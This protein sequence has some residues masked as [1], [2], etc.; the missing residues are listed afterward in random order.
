MI[1]VRQ[2]GLALLAAAAVAV[3]FVM[4]PEEGGLPPDLPT[5]APEASDYADL[6]DQA[7][8]DFEAN[9]ARAD[10]APQ[11]QVVAGW[12][13]KDLLTILALEGAQNVEALDAL[14]DQNDLIY[15]AAT[16]REQ[17]D[18][19]PAALLVIG[20]LAIALWGATSGQPTIELGRSVESNSETRATTDDSLGGDPAEDPGTGGRHRG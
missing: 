16:T 14:T 11:Q 7:L 13:A 19:R 3:F 2:I 12:A 9:E 6:V 5:F 18:D 20:V 1:L 15:R 10:S 17:R 4:E 8:S